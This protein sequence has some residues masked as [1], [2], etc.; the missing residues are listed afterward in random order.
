M[1]VAVVF[2]LCMLRRYMTILPCE[3]CF[4]ASRGSPT[5]PCT[6]ACLPAE[7][8]STSGSLGGSRWTGGRRATSRSSPSASTVTSASSGCAS[9]SAG[10]RGPPPGCCSR[11]CCSTR[12]R[13]RRSR[14]PSSTQVGETREGG[15]TGRRTDLWLSESQPRGRLIV[16]LRLFHIY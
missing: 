12:A 9:W 8:S 5:S 7:I 11:S 4:A 14:P 13:R 6:A 1:V 2:F 16:N 3:R 10:S 15:Q